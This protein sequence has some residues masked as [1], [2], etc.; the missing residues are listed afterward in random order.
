MHKPGQSAL[1]PPRS[2]QAPTDAKNLRGRPRRTSP[3]IFLC[4]QIAPDV[5]HS[6]IA[7]NFPFF[8]LVY[9]ILMSK[10]LIKATFQV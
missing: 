6:I 10:K 4:N 1:P 3:H 9:S 7:I 2:H 5:T 8:H